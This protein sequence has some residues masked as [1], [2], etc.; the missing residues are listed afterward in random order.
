MKT[1]LLLLA[2]FIIPVSVRCSDDKSRIKEHLN[3]RFVKYEIVEIRPDSANIYT[4]ANK[5]RAIEMRIADGNLEILKTLIDIENNKGDSRLNYLYADSTYHKLIRLMEIFE[6]SQF[7]KPDRC[8]YV[9]YLVYKNELKVP[10]EEYY[11]LRL[12][13]NGSY[14]II[15][16]SFDWDEFMAEKGYSE[17]ISKALKYQKEIYDLEHKYKK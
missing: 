6:K 5:L 1:S 11:H 14:D 16:R 13:G 7:S 9:K 10:K 3:N 15:H 17:M 8:Y 4:A 2:V 12:M